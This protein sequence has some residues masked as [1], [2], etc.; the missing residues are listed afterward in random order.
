MGRAAADTS[1]SFLTDSD[2]L[3]S[4]A[5]YSPHGSPCYYFSFSKNFSRCRY[6]MPPRAVTISSHAYRRALFRLL[7]SFF[8]RVTSAVDFIALAFRSHA[9][10][11]ANSPL[12]RYV[13]GDYRHSLPLARFTPHRVSSRP[14]G[15]PPRHILLFHITA[16]PTTTFM[17]LAA[18]IR[19]AVSVESGITSPILTN[20]R[21]RLRPAS[22]R[23]RHFLRITAVVGTMMVLLRGQDKDDIG[24]IS[25][26]RAASTI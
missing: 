4:H 10:R 6:R 14:Q 1:I 22:T 16:T 12:C 7:S 20:A 11:A 17:R 19:M 15:P 8:T 23:R 24:I 2:D 13:E 3:F 26:L 18:S 9:S 21:A 5:A 25:S